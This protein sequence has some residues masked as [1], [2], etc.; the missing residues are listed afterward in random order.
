MTVEKLRALASKEEIDL[1][2]A[3]KKQ[4]II[5]KIRSFLVDSLVTA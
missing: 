1:G 4:E 2:D 5:G 3:T